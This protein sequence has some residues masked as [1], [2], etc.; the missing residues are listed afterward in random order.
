M[1][2]YPARETFNM[3]VVPA[4]GSDG[5]Y[6]QLTDRMCLD[7][8]TGFIHKPSGRMHQRFSRIELPYRKV[9]YV[10]AREKSRGTVR[11]TDVRKML[12]IKYNML[13]EKQ[14]HQFRDE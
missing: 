5:I 7:A 11:I 3:A 13:L 10:R 1:G 8:F 6:I 4:R 12:V 14:L 9:M 2:V